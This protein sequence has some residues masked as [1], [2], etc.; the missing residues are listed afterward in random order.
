MT[1]HVQIS[2]TT[3]AAASRR[4]AAARY[5]AEQVDPLTASPLLAAG[6]ADE[7]LARAY[8]LRRKKTAARVSAVRRAALLR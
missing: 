3:L 1:H 8:R 6:D 7:L 2:S 5:A 4:R